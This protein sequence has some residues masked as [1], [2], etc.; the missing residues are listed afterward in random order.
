MARAGGRAEVGAAIGSWWR[1]QC[2]AMMCGVCCV[3]MLYVAY[4]LRV[5]MYMVQV[6][7]LRMPYAHTCM[8]VVQLSRTTF[9]PVCLLSFLSAARCVGPS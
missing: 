4:A 7:T 1:S 9:V 2:S 3:C 5:S 6:C 8:Y